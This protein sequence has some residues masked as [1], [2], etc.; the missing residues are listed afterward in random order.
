MT[1][2][3]LQPSPEAVELA[4]MMMDRDDVKRK[5]LMETVEAGESGQILESGRT[6]CGTEGDVEEPLQRFPTSVR[7]GRCPLNTS[8]AWHTHVTPD[9]LKHPQ[10]SLPDLAL[11]VFGGM[12]V[13]NVTGVDSAEYFVS[14]GN[15]EQMQ[16]EFRDALGAD[17]RSVDGLLDSITEG[18]VNPARA[19]DRVRQRMPELFFNEATDFRELRGRVA[20]MDHGIRASAPTYTHH[21]VHSI[22][23]RRYARTHTPAD[24]FRSRVR[25]VNDEMDSKTP[26]LNVDL[27]DEAA[28][29]AVGVV[30]G[31]V[32]ERIIFR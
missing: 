7:L 27:V 5:I 4:E 30:V 25:E 1:S 8:G 29:T 20:E 15:A 26:D 32:V 31:G 2:V 6:V 23:A 18:R 21:E 3:V 12:D 10:N 14:A 16:A 11:V 13:I 9:E 24:Q 28:S 22:Y 19:G 17:V